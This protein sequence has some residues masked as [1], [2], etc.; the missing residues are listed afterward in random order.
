M[1]PN[2]ELASKLR[3]G[4]E[5][6]AEATELAVERGATLPILR[7][8][9]EQRRLLAQDRR[10]DGERKI[11]QVPRDLSVSELSSSLSE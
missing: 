9:Q 10:V 11:D 5:L 4:L 6:L 8:L 7:V 2:L 3:D 1:F